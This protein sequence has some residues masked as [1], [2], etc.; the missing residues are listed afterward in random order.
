MLRA[1]LHA[2]LCLAVVSMAGIAAENAKADATRRESKVPELGRNFVVTSPAMAMVWIVPGTF[3]MSSTHGAG[4]DTLVTLTR[5]YWLG[6]TEVTQEQ[7]QAVIEHVPLPSNFKGSDRPVER[8]AWETVVIFCNRLTERE[9]TA[10]RLPAGYV[11]ALPTEAQWEYACRAGTTGHYHGPLD[12][13][14]WHHDN[15]NGQTHPVAQKQP[16][17]WGLYDM[18][19]NVGEWCSDWLASYPGGRVNDPVGAD[20]GQF[21]LIRGGTFDGNAGTCRA[22]FRSWSKV[23]FG[24]VNVGFRVAL[25]PLPAAQAVGSSGQP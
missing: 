1:A 11:Y 22:G 6:R 18:H 10:G 5:G 12:A 23:G 16:N 2:F 8:V 17:A 4:D 24:H 15:S 21:R 25:T 13:V 19:G 9:R 20:V 14:S 3:L 7:W